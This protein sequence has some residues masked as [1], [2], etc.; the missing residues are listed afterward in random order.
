MNVRSCDTRLTVSYQL[1]DWEGAVNQ[2]KKETK[3]VNPKNDSANKKGKAEGGKE[4]KYLQSEK[5]KNAAL[6][7]DQGRI[8]NY[9]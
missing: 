7:T 3:E 9:W 6:C 8:E 4:D 1:F 5:K 2:R